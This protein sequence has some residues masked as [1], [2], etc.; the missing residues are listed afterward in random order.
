MSNGPTSYTTKG[1]INEF[2]KLSRKHKKPL[3]ERIT[4]ELK[5]GRRRKR[6]VNLS[7]INRYSIKGSNVLVLGKVLG[8][9]ELKHSVKIIAFDYSKSALEKLKN[10]NS[11]VKTLQDFAKNPKIPKKV[12]IL[13]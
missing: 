12:I 9:G 10:S 7:K 11:E 6:S 4:D 3:F 1:L 2:E 13:G 5:K 8:S